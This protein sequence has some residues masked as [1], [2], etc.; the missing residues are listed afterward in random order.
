MFTDFKIFSGRRAEIFRKSPTLLII[1][2]PKK[3]CIDLQ[4]L[5]RTHN[6][7]KVCLHTATWHVYLDAKLCCHYKCKLVSY[8]WVYPHLPSAFLPLCF[9]AGCMPHFYWLWQ[10]SWAVC[11]VLTLHSDK[12]CLNHI[13]HG[14]KWVSEGRSTI[15]TSCV[16][17][18][19]ALQCCIMCL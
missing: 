6:K 2:I 12:P 5:E 7:S 4:L 18:P 17:A 16:K 8:D 15:V 1:I 3:L 10:S 9:P 14:N 13:M 19:S 11:R